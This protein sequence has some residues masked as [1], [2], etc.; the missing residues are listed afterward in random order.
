MNSPAQ[1][2]VQKARLLLQQSRYADAERE[3]GRALSQEPNNHDALALLAQLKIDQGKPAEALPL[4]VQALAISPEADYYIYLRAFAHYKMDLNMA[5]LA[6]LD[7]ALALNPYHPGY[8]SLYAFVLID[9][10]RFADALA[11]ANEGLALDADD[12]SCL[13]ARSRALNRLGQ[14]AEAQSTLQDSLAANP[15]ND[16]THTSIGWNYL[17]TGDHKK[18]AQHF[19]EALRLN[20]RS[21]TA[22]AGMKEALKSRIAPYRWFLQYGLWLQ[23]KGK[24]F[25]FYSAIGVYLFFK[26]STWA[27]GKLP[28][29]LD[30]LTFVLAGLYLLLVLSS[31]LIRPIANA[32][33]SFHPQGR[34]ALTLTERLS[35]QTAM[36]ALAMS[37]ILGVAGLLVWS[38]TALA[39]LWVW[40][41]P[42]MATMAIPLGTV[43]YP[44][45]KQ[46][47]PMQWAN[48]GIV[49]L[50]L[51]AVVLL[52]VAGQAGLAWAAAYAIALV[53]GSWVSAFVR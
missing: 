13:N 44:I 8:F 26:I 50:G 27:V 4:L 47:K 12:V 23:Y 10:R 38:T 36:L 30:T 17:E 7:Q 35:S 25:G 45:A 16:W 29:P 31:W 32:F 5:A 9:Q 42:I 24:N 39:P 20:P 19:R 51:L 33:L 14:T 41:A 28:P 21:G 3:I 46:Y 37:L 43:Q 2:F 6:D 18:A 48:V 34:F 11:K 22:A 53:L 49:A 40:S 1:A 52:P 15:E